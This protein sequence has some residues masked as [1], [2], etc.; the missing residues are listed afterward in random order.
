MFEI[1]GREEQVFEQWEQG[2]KVSNPC[3]KAGDEVVFRNSSGA[4]AVM[5]AREESGQVVADVPNKLLQMCCN[6]LVDL[7]QGNDRHT[8]C[9]TTFT[10]NPAQKPDGYKCADNSVPDTRISYNELKDKPFGEETEVLFDQRVEF[11]EV[12]GIMQYMGKIPELPEVGKSYAVDYNG[13]VYNCVAGGENGV[14]SFI[15]NAV[16]DGGDDTGEPFMIGAMKN[17]VEGDGV[18]DMVVYP[19]DGSTSADIRIEKPVV[20]KLDPKLH[21]GLPHYVSVQNLP[22]LGV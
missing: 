1:V 17:A 8:E 20:H 6:I 22:H 13:T 21:P 10:V 19:L 9:R 11:A 16:F 5:I 4:T 18:P 12:E 3:M 15:G 7:E 14:V 2:A